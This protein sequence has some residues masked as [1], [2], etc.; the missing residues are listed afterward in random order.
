MNAKPSYEELEKQVEQLTRRDRQ[1]SR[2]KKETEQRLATLIDN[3]PGTAYRCLC[4]E[5]W[6]MLYVSSGCEQLTGFLP[7]EL[8]SNKAIAYNEL[9]LPQDR[10]HVSDTIMEAVAQQQ[11]FTVEYRIT[12][13]NKN[14]KWV[15]EKGIAVKE[16]K[17]SPAILEG[18]IHDISGKKQSETELVQ[19]EAMLSGILN[20]MHSGVLLVDQDGTIIFANE[21]MTELFGYGPQDLIGKGYA[22]LTH[23]SETAEAKTKMFQLI[24]GEIDLVSLERRYQRKDKSTFPGHL[25]GRRLYRPDGTFW[26]LVGVL[27]D[28]SGKKKTQNALIESET[29]L[30]A[31]VNAVP[32]LIWLKDQNG[33]YLG[34]NKTFERFFGAKESEI[35]GKTDYHFVD[36]DLADF[37]MEHDR[38]AVAAGRPSINEESL[39]FAEDNYHGMFETI[40]TPILGP[41]GH[42]IGVLGVAR[43]ITAR[44]KT[45][46]ALLLS[47]QKLSLHLLQTPLAV[48]ELDLNFHISSW[49]PAAEKIF[50][51]SEKEI[52]GQHV[53]ILVPKEDWKYI[54]TTFNKLIIKKGGNRNTNRNINKKGEI[55][56]CEWFNTPI[57]NES[58]KIIAFVSLGQNITGR[59]TAEEK[60]RV[61]EERY[62]EL[63]EN[64]TNGVAVYSVESNGDRFI[65]KDFN[66][67]AE[68]ITL[69]ERSKVIGK[70]AAKAFPGLAPAGIIDAFRQVYKTGKAQFLPTIY[71]QDTTLSLW[72][73]HNIYK[74]PSGDIVSV[75]NDVSDKKKAKQELQ[76]ERDKLQSIINGMG[77]ML[78]IVNKDYQIEFQNNLFHEKFGNLL[79]KKC[80]RHIFGLDQPCH[81]CRMT[82]CLG[83]N[84]IHH[85]E[86]KTMQN[87]SYEISFSPFQEA[88]EEAKT[89]ILLR[90]VTEKRT[91]QAEAMRAG[92]L[93]SL[94]E[95][96]AGVAHE[97][98]NPV[99][100]IISIAEI[101]SDKFEDLGGERKIPERI[102]NEAER[103]SRIVKNL[104]SFAR[105]KKDEH[106][107]VNINRILEKTLELAEKQIFKD[108]IHL[109]V[110]LKGSLPD[111]KANDHEIQQVFMNLI[112]NARYALNKKYPDADKNKQLEITTQ[113]IETEH[114]KHVRIVFHD[115][116]MGISRNILHAITNPFFSTKPPGEGTGLGL[117]ISHGIVNNHGG[118]LLFSSREG[119]YTKVTVDLPVNYLDSQNEV[120]KKDID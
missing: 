85:S 64:M 4:D 56:F 33:V 96:A 87:K 10:R 113:L 93:A 43:D 90:D 70:D 18:F 24:K 40:K 111:I 91:L 110:T 97:I 6:T 46:D 104:L 62:R 2:K 55:L 30:R 7:S 5:N 49:N 71:Y 77:D 67:A 73:E 94:G 92:H 72:V 25:S 98:N 35:I 12:D 69:I 105:I 117:S 58:G 16:N 47:R 13:K 41:E 26:A 50:G 66:T 119:R 59:K 34:C 9:I 118:K 44:K 89:A 21:R 109:S 79:R 14:I 82:A 42:T 8:I 60:L 36:K 20:A 65:F 37:F 31:L 29:R 99:T 120:P 68:R 52:L 48:M 75:F 39:T 88:R 101:L 76:V 38:K 51:Y 27:T 57:V 3:I 106:S 114:E 116:G 32:D 19:R 78:Y 63:F 11:P 22:A 112:S 115:H 108:G 81:F 84:S 83:D 61:N 86:T 23:G 45:E 102:I 95:L 80:Y 74:L 100:G 1:L 103:I 17:E 107:L 15:W 53:A 54:E 28:I